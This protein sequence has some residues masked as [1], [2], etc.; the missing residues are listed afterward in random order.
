MKVRSK[1]E[2]I[3]CLIDILSDDLNDSSWTQTDN[4]RNKGWVEC[5]KWVLGLTKEERNV[6]KATE[7]GE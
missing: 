2:I 1:D 4:D 3:I 7:V 6:F 5:L